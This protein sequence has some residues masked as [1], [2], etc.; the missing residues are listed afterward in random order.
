MRAVPI[1]LTVALLAIFLAQR[2]LGAKDKA[3]ASLASREYASK[4][5]IERWIGQLGDVRFAVREEATRKLLAADYPVAVL[6]PVLNSPD[7][8][9]RVRARRIMTQQRLVARERL[10]AELPIMAKRGEMDRYI[11][12]LMA[13]STLLQHEL[14]E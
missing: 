5:E 8:E 12:A 4:T 11:A 7:A 14:E 3:A 9:V 2:D 13:H 1:P 6:L 10:F